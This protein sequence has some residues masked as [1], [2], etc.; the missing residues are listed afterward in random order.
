MDRGAWRPTVQGVS[1]SWTG[2]SAF[3]FQISFIFLS[4][5]VLGLCCFE[6]PSLVVAMG[7]YSLVVASGG[8]ALVV[9][10]GLLIAVASL[11]VELR[12]WAP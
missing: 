2:L 12:L 10:R 7:S 4:L 6:G 1:K 9:G 3:H 5:A 8:H 11:V